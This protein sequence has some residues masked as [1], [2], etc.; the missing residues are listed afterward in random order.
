M[1]SV[2]E[3]LPCETCDGTGLITSLGVDEETDFEQPCPDCTEVDDEDE[4][5]RFERESAAS[6]ERM[7]DYGGEG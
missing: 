1:V 6:V 4:T 3:I 2:L 5:A 7:F